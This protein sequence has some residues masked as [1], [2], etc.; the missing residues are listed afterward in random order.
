MVYRYNVTQ[1]D[2]DS[3]ILHFEIY[4]DIHYKDKYLIVA[5]FF[6]YQMMGNILGVVPYLY[7][8]V[9]M[10]LSPILNKQ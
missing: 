9:N 7:I 10:C 8:Y 6:L 5:L 2:S 4:I 3:G 1:L